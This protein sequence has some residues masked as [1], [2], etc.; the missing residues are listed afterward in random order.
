M[1]EST[2]IPKDISQYLIYISEV[3]NL[4]ENTTKSYRRDLKKLSTFIDELK[5]SDYSDITP[6]ICSAWI[7]N[8]YNQNNNPKSIQRHLS[9]AKGFFRF[10]KKII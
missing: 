8:L 9:S 10:L 2:F 4:S 7:G 1:N 5:I 3:K 6:E